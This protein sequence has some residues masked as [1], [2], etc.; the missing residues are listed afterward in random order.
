MKVL[1]KLKTLVQK[2]L[3][4]PSLRKAFNWFNYLL[5]IL[6]S[7]SRILS[8]VFSSFATG[9]FLRE[10][11]AVVN[12]RLN[13]YRRAAFGREVNWPLIRRNTHRLEKGMV[14]TPRRSIFALDYI[15]E[16]VNEFIRIPLEE[17]RPDVKWCQDVLQKYFDCIEHTELTTFL[18]QTFDESAQQREADLVSES[19]SPYLRKETTKISYGDFAELAGIR[20]SVRYFEGRRVDRDVL[21]KAF[22]VASQAP[23]ACNRQPFRYVVFDDPQDAPEI[24][25]I[26]F[27]TLGYGE[28][29]PCVA[30]VVGSLDN[31][32][33]PRDRHVIYIDGAL[34]AMSLMFSLETLGLSSCPINWPDFGPLENKMGKALGL[35]AFERPIMLIAIG[36]PDRSI[37]I[38]YSKKKCIDQIREYRPFT[39]SK[40][41]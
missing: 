38:A 9:A 4:I 37:P 21:D 31:Y 40:A 35:S 23:S 28:S 33:S 39:E 5:L 11:H 18:K 30:V 16:T 29:V 25:S 24:A 10:Q 8:A 14:L 17:D 12:G 7:K 20:R 6:I 32:P 27:G 13:Y 36:Y 3:A 19:F 22:D 41:D 2:I 34:S 15:E 26:P 1:V